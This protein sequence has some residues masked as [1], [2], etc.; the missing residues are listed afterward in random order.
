MLLQDLKAVSARNPYLSV[1]LLAFVQNL[2]V[3]GKLCQP[4]GPK[5]R[6]CKAL[7]CPFMLLLC[8]AL[9]HNVAVRQRWILEELRKA[10]LRILHIH[11][12]C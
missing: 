6:T 4:A 12:Q 11:E 8:V 5:L 7:S 3:P 2:C 10:I 1:K 9:N